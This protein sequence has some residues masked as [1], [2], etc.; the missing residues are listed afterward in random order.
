MNVLLTYEQSF[1]TFHAEN[2]ENEF[3]TSPKNANLNIIL[4]YPKI[5][6]RILDKKKS[7]T[8]RHLGF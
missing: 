6:N 1:H 7:Q 8:A 3:K 2:S 4:I 5:R